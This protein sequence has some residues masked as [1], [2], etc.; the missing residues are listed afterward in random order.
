MHATGK[1]DNEEV[2]TFITR[3]VERYVSKY[4]RVVSD[5]PRECI[6]A[7]TTNQE[8]YFTDETGARRYW[9]IYAHKVDLNWLKENLEQLWA[10]AVHA[11]E[12][13]EH[14]WPDREFEEDVIKPQQGD[15]RE[16]PPLAHPIR[17]YLDKR[18]DW[19]IGEP[20]EF[21]FEIWKDLKSNVFAQRPDIDYG[22]KDN[23]KSIEKALRF[24]GYKNDVK[25]Y[26]NEKGERVPTRKWW[27]PKDKMSKGDKE[28]VYPSAAPKSAEEPP[29]FMEQTLDDDGCSDFGEVEGV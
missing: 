10:E 2:K 5:E 9:P 20:G 26:P 24:L 15:R 28:I 29:P 6:F 14:W 3:R 17:K 21:Q 1:A 19:P 7:G 13:G 25:R 4:G 23:K 12:N 22:D 16:E 11:Y 8:G 27:P 18:G